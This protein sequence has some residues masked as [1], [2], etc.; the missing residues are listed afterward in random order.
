M[1]E[2]VTRP[3]IGNADAFGDIGGRSG[4]ETRI[5]LHVHS[6][7]SGF[8]TNWWVRGLGL[9]IETRESYTTPDEVWSRARLA[10]MDFVT[11]TDHESLAGAREL[12]HRPR[13][14]TGVEVNARFPEDSSSVD[15][16]IYG[17]TDDDHREIQS[18]RANVYTLVDFLRESRL[19]H[20]LAHPLFDLGA[21]LGKA[22][23]E[24]RMV[25][26]PAWELINGARPESQ[27]RLAV[28]ITAL[29]D[30]TTL[31]ALARLH[32]LPAPDHE[33]IVGAG[34]SDDHGGLHIGRAWTRLPQVTGVTDLLAAMRAGEMA[35]GGASGSVD[36][37]THTAFAIAANAVAER[38]DAVTV[39][40]PF[41]TLREFLPLV[42]AL[43]SDQIRHLAAARY[44]AR[45]TQSFSTGEAGFQPVQLLASIGRLVE[46]HLVVAPYV[47][48]HSYFGRERRKAQALAQELGLRDGP[49]RVGVVVDDLDE[50][51]GVATMYRNL[52]RVARGNE[53]I[54]ITL[55]RCREEE[56][57]DPTSPSI[58]PVSTVPLPLYP[59]RTLN[60]PS[61]LDV[62]D[63][64][65]AADY[66]VVH[67]ATP[68]PLGL[69]ALFAATTLGLPAIG[70]YHTEYAAYARVLSGDH[71]LG[72]L[73]E[74]LSREFYRR[75]SAIA[76]PSLADWQPHL[77]S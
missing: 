52:E 40:E 59:G 44:E 61:L 21:R 36:A 62:F 70:A 9:G 51:H 45:L 75:C 41:T 73:V 11:L 63:H 25:L 14:L 18:R 58:R 35:P 38:P 34:G 10:G 8:A 15:I 16:L 6:L 22:Q 60:V 32:G 76:A 13:F 47:A 55:I 4:D 28:R 48:I 71:I 29:A 64:F 3:R 24:K 66:D 43:S 2:L 69:A 23:V 27:G 37:M 57:C 5:D 50:I 46:G 26:F 12:W 74:A 56:G 30:G 54:Q 39:P 42:P 65:A 20:V 33:R 17:L 7:A 53:E 49:L 77:G 19:V 67:L 72:D 31:R 1:I 68:G